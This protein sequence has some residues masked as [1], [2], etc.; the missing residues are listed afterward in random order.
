MGCSV[1]EVGNLFGYR[2]AAVVRLGSFGQV[3]GASIA[4]TSHADQVH[5]AGAVISKQAV[6]A[7]FPSQPRS[8]DDRGSVR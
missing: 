1:V 8:G 4:V 2:H 3:S 7:A 5:P 6:Q